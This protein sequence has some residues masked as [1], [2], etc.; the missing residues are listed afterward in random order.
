M[1]R[2]PQNDEDSVCWHWGRLTVVTVRFASDWSQQQVVIFS[3]G[4]RCGSNT[5]PSGYRT[6]DPLAMVNPPG[7]LP[8]IFAFIPTARRNPDGSRRD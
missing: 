7:V 3:M 2:S 8:P 1:R 4:N 5:I 6:A